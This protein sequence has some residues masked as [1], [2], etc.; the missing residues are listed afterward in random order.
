MISI[1]LLS[2]VTERRWQHVLTLPAVAF[3]VPFSENQPYSHGNGDSSLLNLQ[4]MSGRA[5]MA[6]TERLEILAAPAPAGQLLPR[7][8]PPIFMSLQWRA[9]LRE[10][11]S[12]SQLSAEGI[13]AAV[14]MIDVL[15]A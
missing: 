14:R 15:D 1:K 13:I 8:G 7:A 9:G 6:L 4:G 3:R 10:T 11:I 5:G 12:L 2:K